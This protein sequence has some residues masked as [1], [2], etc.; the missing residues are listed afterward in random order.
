MESILIGTEAIN[1]TLDAFIS[2]EICVIT[3]RCNEWILIFRISDGTHWC[4]NSILWG[5][6]DGLLSQS[7]YTQENGKHSED[8]MILE[9]WP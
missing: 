3:Y 7:L 5:G 2:Y 8:C 9:P 4:K 6:F 1:N